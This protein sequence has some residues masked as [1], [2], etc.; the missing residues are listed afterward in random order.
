MVIYHHLKSSNP[1]RESIIQNNDFSDI[2]SSD[3]SCSL[4]INGW[5]AG[6]F[7]FDKPGGEGKDYNR[8]ALAPSFSLRLTKGESDSLDL[9]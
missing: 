5:P 4:R 1:G 3:K 7:S 8:C 6:T 9:S 2:N